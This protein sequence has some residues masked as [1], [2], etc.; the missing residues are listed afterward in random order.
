MDYSRDLKP[1]FTYLVAMPLVAWF[2]FTLFT[3]FMAGVFAGFLTQEVNALNAVFLIVF[4]FVVFYSIIIYLLYLYWKSYSIELT[5]DN[6]VIKHGVI[7]KS[8]SI[9][10]YSEIQQVD[11]QRNV[12][13]HLLGVADVQVYT[14]SFQSAIG[15]VIR[16]L[17]VK[18]AEWLR[19][20]LS[21]KKP[22]AKSKALKTIAGKTVVQKASEVP[23]AVAEL[24][25]GKYYAK[26]FSLALFSFLVLV[27][28]FVFVSLAIGW[29]AAL[30]FLSL[31]FVFVFVIGVAFL[32][33]VMRIHTL[34]FQLFKNHAFLSY[35]MGLSSAQASMPFESIQD[36]SVSQG[37]FEKLFGLSTL[38]IQTGRRM[39]FVSN[40]DSYQQTIT[41]VPALS[42]T[43]A[44]RLKNELLKRIK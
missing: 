29:V 26:S 1:S 24:M 34:K 30:A 15:G 8:I 36:V 23:F 39:A 10:S 42:Q 43:E 28:L 14:M 2:F 19:D 12:F 21:A 6:I 40:D 7:T 4:L 18:H 27:F 17:P 35:W 31:L 3:A 38:T 25:R 20:F 22:S 13:S 11:L 33:D 32:A 5:K 44:Q 41:N 16:G 9:F 37:L